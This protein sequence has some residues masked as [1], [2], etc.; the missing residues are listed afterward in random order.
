MAERFDDETWAWLHEIRLRG[1]M[2][3]GDEPRI[4]E[5]VEA[6][7]LLRRG[8]IVAVTQIGKD[9][10][11]DRLRLDPDSEEFGHCRRAYERFLRLDKQ[12]KDLTTQ[13][14]L[15]TSQASDTY[16]PEEWDLVDRLA[17]V[18]EKAGPIVAELG[19]A[20]PR[21]CEYRHRLRKALE[22]LQGGDR[23]WFCGVK[24]DSYH[25]VWWHLHEDLLLALGIARSEDPNQ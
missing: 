16:G 9:A 24:C 13:W 3:V 2:R 11:A 14:Q 5:L 10:D 15:S 18:D 1:T 22:Q 6:G 23:Q 25:T 19:R 12:V 7:Y 8:P 20:V 17:A 4:D 21:F